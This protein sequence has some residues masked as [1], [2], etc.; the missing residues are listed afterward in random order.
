MPVPTMVFDYD[1]GWHQREVQRSPSMAVKYRIHRQ[2]YTDLQL[3]PP[4][5]SWGRPPGTVVKNTVCDTGAQLNVMD[6]R[7]LAEMGI[8]V[9]SITPTTT[10]IMGAARGSQLDVKGCVFLE[11]TIPG[12]EHKFRNTVPQQFFVVSNVK[13]T[14]L[15]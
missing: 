3:A 1:K 5:S 12:G 2:S 13:S 7:T 14:Y 9:T 8:D 6:T 15:S 11:V 4:R 10:C